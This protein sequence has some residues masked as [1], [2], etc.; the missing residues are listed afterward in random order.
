LAATLFNRIILVALAPF[1]LFNAQGLSANDDNQTVIRLATTTSTENSG[2]LGYLLPHFER[3]SGIETHVIAV[4]TGK[5][6]RMGKD[7]DVDLILVHAK[8]AELAFVE[9]GYGV[10]RYSVMYNDF[11]LVGPKND[12]ANIRQAKNAADA[13]V[14][15]AAQ[16]ERFISRGDD[17]GTNKKELSLWKSADIDPEGSWYM[18]AGQ[19]MGKVLQIAGELDAYTLTDRGTWIAYQDR[20]PLSIRFEG[21]AGLH[22][23]YGIIAVNPE[24]Y[25]DVNQQGA[26]K[27][28][29]WIISP[30]AQQLIGD[31][32]IE[33]TRLF[34]P[35]SDPVQ[36]VPG[37]N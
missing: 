30:G 20:S 29:Q 5:A 9:A 33:G 14:R 36:P 16:Q 37:T 4:G 7:G 26:D 24:R 32:R 12:P 3:A 31:Y 27:L 15:I 8:P 2:L 28:I 10:Q 13:L 23:P 35:A 19:G 21:D 1:V 25:P 34:I 22:N 18:E 6:L 17:S 11:V